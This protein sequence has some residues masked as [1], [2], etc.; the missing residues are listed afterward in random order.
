M[1]SLGVVLVILG[2]LML[3][4]RGLSWTRHREVLDVGKFE[5]TVKE[6]KEIPFSPVVGLLVVGAGVALLYGSRRRLD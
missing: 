1:R 2:A 6:K 5:A 4:Y 3:A